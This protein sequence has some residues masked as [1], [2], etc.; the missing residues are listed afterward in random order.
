MENGKSLNYGNQ[1]LV[2]RYD[3]LKAEYRTACLPAVE[4]NGRFWA[5]SHRK[6]PECVCDQP[7]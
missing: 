4:G 5:Q 3:V 7:V 1:I 6:R 2:L